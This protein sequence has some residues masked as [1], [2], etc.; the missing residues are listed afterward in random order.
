MALAERL[1]V[2]GLRRQNWEKFSFGAWLKEAA[3]FAFQN[4]QRRSLP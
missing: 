3:S 2:P 4:M 1:R